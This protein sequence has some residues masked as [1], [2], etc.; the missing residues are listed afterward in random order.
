MGSTLVGCGK[1]MPALKIGNTALEALVDTSDEWIAS[2]TGIKTRCIAIEETS[3]DLGEAAARQAL[4]WTAGG[5][6]ER[7]LIP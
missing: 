3:A 1:A 5:Y 7:P 2:R 4:G 6:S